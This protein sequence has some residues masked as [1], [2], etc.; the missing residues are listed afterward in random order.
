MKSLILLSGLLGFAGFG[1]LLQAT[2][3][4]VESY[5]LPYW[6]VAGV[7]TPLAGVIVYL[8]ALYQKQAT[9]TEAILQEYVKTLQIRLDEANL[10][11]YELQRDLLDAKISSTKTIAEATS[12][13]G[14]IEKQINQIV[15]YIEKKDK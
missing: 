11:K 4:P 14:I 5:G 12:K 9:K 3:L 1:V 2:P 10:R 15:D 7:V 13:A 6:L 8:N